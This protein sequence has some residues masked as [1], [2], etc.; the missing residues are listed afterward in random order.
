MFTIRFLVM[1]LAAAIVSAS[2]TAFAQESTAINAAELKKY[3]EPKSVTELEWQLM[4]F[5]IYWQGAF[6][7]SSDYI[8]SNPV[9]FD[10]KAMRFVSSFRVSDK[11]ESRDPE[12]FFRLPR[13][14]RE[15]IL[16]SGVNYLKDL[17]ARFFPELA[18]NPGLLYVEFQFRISGGGSSTVASYEKGTLILSE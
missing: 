3:F 1:V 9:H 8:T 10:F 4:S 18:A 7:G 14:R 6:V 15:A 12:P 13:H 5:N 17:L 11:R 16:Q 2:P